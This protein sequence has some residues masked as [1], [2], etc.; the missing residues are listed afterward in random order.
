MIFV[1]EFLVPLHFVIVMS[2]IK[3]IAP[4]LLVVLFMNYYANTILFPHSHIING[5]TI[6]H[7]HSHTDSHHDTKT[8]GHTQSDI[9][10][11]AQ[12][13]HFDY[14]DFSCDCVLNS[15]PF[16]LHE[17]KFV[18]TAHWII[19]IYLQNLSLRAPPIV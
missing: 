1:T 9:V 17:N 2:K 8:G 5:T 3:K 18:E 14:I 15:F 10:L 16:Q 19:P 13:S 6:A 4:F 11:I 12:I 7:S